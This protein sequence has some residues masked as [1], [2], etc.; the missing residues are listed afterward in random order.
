MDLESIKSLSRGKKRR[1]VNSKLNRSAK[2]SELKLKLQ[3]LI[4]NYNLCLSTFIYE[5]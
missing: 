5:K 4:Q 1:C 2:K 3:T